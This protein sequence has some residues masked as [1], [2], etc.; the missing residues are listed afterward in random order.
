MVNNNIISNKVSTEVIQS[1]L[2]TSTRYNFNVY[3]K[4]ILYR[5]VELT[6]MDLRHQ[7][8][9]KGIRIH[10][11]LFRAK[12]ITMPISSF[13]VRSKNNDHKRVRAAFRRLAKITSEWKDETG[14]GGY[15]IIMSY[16]FPKYS[17]EVRF[18]IHDR[19]YDDLM[20]FIK[21]YTQ[22]ELDIAFGFH[23]PY[24]MR[25]YELTSKNKAPLIYPI[26]KLRSIFCLENRY[27]DTSDFIRKVVASAQKELEAS[28]AP[29]YFTYQPIKTGRAFT[30]IRFIS[31]H[32]PE[33][34]RPKKHYKQTNLWKINEILNLLNKSLNT[35][36]KTWQPHENL[37]T[38]VHKIDHSEIEK[39]L[40]KAQTAKNPI[41]Y[42]INALK[43]QL[44]YLR[45]I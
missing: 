1:N 7:S 16:E 25:L 9:S 18:L 40:R 37:L 29:Y 43:K 14:E 6:Q 45:S 41:G 3:E 26:E 20:N 22:Y 35:T 12:E 17:N 32:R 30:H 10:Q 2:V 42:T 28:K 23:S 38:R 4:R 5:I 36:N 24:T 15:Q 39:I 21:G 27:K 11:Q 33:Y 13:L 31:C 34:E 44:A 8:I 19:L